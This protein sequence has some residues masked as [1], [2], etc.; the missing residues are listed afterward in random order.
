MTLLFF[1]LQEEHINNC[2]KKNCLKNVTLRLKYIKYSETQ[3]TAT[4]I[5]KALITKGAV[6]LDEHIDHILSTFAIIAAESTGAPDGFTHGGCTTTCTRE[7]YDHYQEHD[8][9]EHAHSILNRLT[10]NS[11]M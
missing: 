7:G 10:T 11:N 8:Y 9:Q 4:S 2:L 1:F 6:K 5:F 3:L